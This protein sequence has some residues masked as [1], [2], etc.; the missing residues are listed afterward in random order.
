MSPVILIIALVAYLALL[1][2]IARVGDRRRFSASSWTRHPLVYTLALGVYCTSWTFYG[3]VG[4]AASR[5]WYYLPI[6]LGPI[7]LFT[8]GFP[9]LQRIASISR[10]ENIHSIADFITS[11][12]GKRQS[13][14]VI[15]TLIMLAT[16]VPYI[17]LQLKA[18]SDTLLF[19]VDNSAFAGQDMTLFV[20]AVMA[21]FTLIF[22]A[23]RLDVASYHSGIMAAIAFESLV[24]L[25]A[26][27]AIAVFAFGLSS[28]F[29]PAAINNNANVVFQE[30]TLTPSF[31][32]LTLVSAATIF[33]LPRMFQ[34]T[35]VECLSEQHL[36]FA[37]RGFSIYLLVIAIAV[38]TISWV[39]N[40]VLAGTDVTIDTYVLALPLETG[41]KLLGLLGFIGGF[42]AA[43]AMIIVASLTLSQMLS[44]DVILPLLIRQQKSRG[45]IPDY[46]RAL[47]LARRLTVIAVIFMAWLYQHG[48][49]EN[50]ALTEIGLIA[51]AL[52]VQLAPAMVFGLYWQ[53]GNASGMFA[54]LACGLPIWFITLMVPLLSN[55]GLIDSQ[56]LSTGLF[57]IELLRPEQLF[58]ITFSD[59][60]TRGVVLSIGANILAFY[61][62]SSMDVTRLSDR[63]QAV[64]FVNRERA[65]QHPSVHALRINKIDLTTMLSQFLGESATQRLLQNET[66]PELVIASP[67]L[68]DYAEQALAGVVGV[69]SARAMLTSL[70]K[71]ESL[72]VED[73]VNIFEETTRSLQFSQDMLFASFES[74]SSAISVVN[75][76]LKIVAWN[77]RYEEMFNYPQGML[78]V[79]RYVA[80][81]V[82]FNA[83]RGL[84]GTGSIDEQVQTRINH[85]LAGKSY[86]VIRNHDQGIIEIKGRPLA[87][88][89]YVTTYDDISEFINTQNELEKANLNLE[90][91]VRER[92]EEIEKINQSLREEVNKR[93]ATEVEL[94]KAKSAAESSNASK[95]QFL[96]IA[97]HDILQP[98]NAANLYAS[99]LIEKNNADPEFGNSLHH[100]HS[101]ICSAELIISNLMEISRL[102]TGSLKPKNSQFA[103]HDVLEPLVNDFRVQINPDVSFHWR[104]TSLWV[105]S[106]AKYLRRILQNYLSNAVKY[107]SRGK[108]LLGCRRRGEQIEICVYDTGPGISKAHQRRIFDDFY[109]VANNSDI[110][111]AGLGLG[112]ALRFAQLLDCK[113]H[114]HSDG[115]HGSMFSVFVPMCPEEICQENKVQTTDI[116]SGLENLTVFY[117]DDDEHNIH[118][119]GTLMD[120]W[121]CEFS[122]ATSAESAERYAQDNGAPDVILMD[123]QLGADINGIQLAETLQNHWGDVPVCIVSAAPDEDLPARVTGCGYEFLRKPIKPG[124]LR[125]LLERY[126]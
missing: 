38:F 102:D 25:V 75:A 103:L 88:G 56:I 65:R 97:S 35:F 50:I 126:L 18:V 83:E 24:K 100:L 82:R 78:R 94:L 86:R 123:Y 113:V 72:G 47:I 63:I 23:N 116:P 114:V 9:L 60:Y 36:K 110:E 14:A 19:S 73:V 52:A 66:R 107:T 10:Q 121:E 15:V 67:K 108:I 87:K 42:S 12:Y 54:G 31:W 93:S 46:S 59:A 53:R 91:R 49:A 79:G 112:I 74:I 80:D 44:N 13:I 22:G 70:S 51:F 16:A 37:R 33:C 81:L 68:L 89:G 26:L 32:V 71:G 5:G 58:G 55:A 77:K 84:L 92:T 27:V 11:R 85:L 90:Q 43:T 122:Y 40:Q 124:K 98:L 1:F 28:G 111:G 20:T 6:L 120:N 41:N 76:D 48:L 57:G 104:P 101:A 3:L 117:V 4:T 64:A 69:A 61:V 2:W 109:R 45:P 118:A 106:D 30:S 8:I 95:T 115:S 99:A 29:D 62:V 34:V 17:A 21:L 119:L 105:K 125:A 7:L 39:G 96:A